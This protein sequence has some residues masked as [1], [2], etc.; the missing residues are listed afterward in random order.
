MLPWPTTTSTSETRK[1]HKNQHF[2]DRSSLK[3]PCEKASGPELDR[4]VEELNRI[5]KELDSERMSS[6][7]C[8]QLAEDV[9][10]MR[11]DLRVSEKQKI[12]A[13]EDTAALEDQVYEQEHRIQELQRDLSTANDQANRLTMELTKLRRQASGGRPATPLQSRN[14]FNPDCM[15][16]SSSDHSRR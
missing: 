7:Q 13:L 16:S 1:F 14:P 12:R 8:R 5:K 11:S 4:L 15:G 3:F 10:K 6:G 2:L 9:A